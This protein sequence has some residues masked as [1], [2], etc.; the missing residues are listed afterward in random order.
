MSPGREVCPWV[1]SYELVFVLLWV[2][3]LWWREKKAS[4][5]DAFNILGT[6]QTIGFSGWSWYGHVLLQ[7][8]FGVD[9][10]Q[11][12]AVRRRGGLRVGT[13]WSDFRQPGVMHAWPTSAC[14]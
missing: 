14:A 8:S 11:F 2:H 12:S 3:I 9:D 4:L 13:L 5:V 7:L 6:V 10:G 1:A